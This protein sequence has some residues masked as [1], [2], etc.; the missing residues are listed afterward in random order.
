MGGGGGGVEH[1]LQ[2]GS[3]GVIPVRLVLKRDASNSRPSQP[4]RSLILKL[5]RLRV[6]VMPTRTLDCTKHWARVCKL[7]VQFFVAVFA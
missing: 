3:F 4:T 2:L 6:T 7:R 5:L 1:S